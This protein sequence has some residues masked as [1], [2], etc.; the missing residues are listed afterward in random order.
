MK[1]NGENVEIR[2]IKGNNAEHRKTLQN[3]YVDW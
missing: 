3:K 1:S 2:E